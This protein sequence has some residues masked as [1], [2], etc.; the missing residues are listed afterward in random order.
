[1]PKKI[2][3]CFKNKL[4]FENLLKAHYR[5]RRHKMYKNEVIRFEMNLE[6]N[7]WNLERSILNK[8][9][10]VG[11][12]RE[13]RIYEPKERIIK[14]LPYI[15]RVVHQWYIEEFIKPYILPRFV[16][17]SFAC[18]ENRGTHK[19]VDKVQEYMREFYRNQGD[20]WILKCDI[21]KYFYNID[22]Q[23]LMTILQKYIRDNYLLDFTK[24]LIYDGRKSDESVGIPIGN[25][26][27][28][29]FANIYLNELDY[30][31]KDKLHIKCYVRY[32]DDFV[33][34]VR[35]KK[36]AKEVLEKIRIF[37][38]EEL[39]LELNNNTRYYPNKMGIN[40]CGYRVFGE[41]RL[42]RKR[43]IKKIRCNVRKWEEDYRNGNLNKKKM[44]L[45]WYS[46][47]GHAKHANSYKLV[48]ECY[49]RIKDINEL[50]CR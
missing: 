3:N 31:I 19:A 25:Y 20:F 38:K 35:N 29:F 34:M 18:L 36:E 45:S 12:Y 48:R 41:Y 40:F 2:T 27:S 43:S 17:T 46:F 11:T 50:I 24:L 13:F 1:M 26:T 28:Q 15:D 33:I 10:H 44:Q 49:L 22:P 9:Y 21:R 23:I 39:H 7:I 6:N 4:T 32:C 37:L 30:Y 47:L 8:T 5:A 14:A 42:L 16:S